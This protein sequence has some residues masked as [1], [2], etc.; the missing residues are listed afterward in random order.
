MPSWSAHHCDGKE[1]SD[2]PVA[3]E[4]VA[5]AAVAVAAAAVEVDDDKQLL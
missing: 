3:A 5:A 4:A 2:A 1:R